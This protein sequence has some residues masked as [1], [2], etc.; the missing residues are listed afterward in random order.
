MSAP[1][2]IGVLGASRIADAAI[3]A[4]TRET[5]DV[6]A[7]VAA[8][9]PDRALRYAADR[10]FASAAE[11]YAALVADDSLDLVYIGLPNALHAEWAVRALAAGRNV[12]VEK[13]FAANLAEF[14]GVAAA[15]ERAPGWAWEAFH[16]ADHPA[17][18]RLV[19]VVRAGGIGELR[20]VDVHVDMPAPGAD[21]PRWSFELAGGALMD[22]GCYALHALLLLGD[23]LAGSALPALAAPELLSARARR[24]VH[25]DRVDAEVVAELDLGGVPVRVH[26]SMVSPEWNFGLRVS[27]S[28]GETVLPNFVKPQEEGRLIVRTTT[29]AGAEERVE[30]VGSAASYAYQLR[31]VREAVRSGERS[32]AGFERSRRTMALI[33]AVY[34]RAGLPPR[35][36]RLSTSRA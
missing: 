30:D 7:S 17:L 16:Y 22:L 36:G 34:A 26:T 27:G 5:G 11:S 23:A 8:R 6:R 13:P 28:L 32:A 33:D 15:M 2:R 24:W 20:G 21:D 1:L 31:R 10:G 35:P 25:D 12:L 14:D 29:G 4:A 19:D 9:D 3:V 18:H